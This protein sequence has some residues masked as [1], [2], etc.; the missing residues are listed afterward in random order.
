MASE[1]DHED[2]P[3][4]AFGSSSELEERLA[5]LIIAGRKQATVWGGDLPNPTAPGMRWRVTAQG[6]DVAVIETV[7][8]DRCRF[9]EIDEAFAYSEGEGDRSLAY[10][11][12]VHE[13]YF[14][15]QGAFAPDMPIWREHFRLV[16]V[17]DEVLAADTMRHIAAEEDEARALLA[18]RTPGVTG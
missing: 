9:D 14:R 2:L 7:S 18:A 10:W 6:R 12:I 8:V 3:S 15:G 5:A 11:R 16:A 1:R 4:T 17:I 13:D